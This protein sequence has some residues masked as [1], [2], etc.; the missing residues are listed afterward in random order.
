MAEAEG[1]SLR[2]YDIIYRLTEDIEKALKGMLEPEEV[3][4]VIGHAEVRAVFHI[5]KVGNI[6]GCRVLD[7][8][9]YL[10]PG[11]IKK[12]RDTLEVL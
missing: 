1:V 4:T 6:A 8:E 2:L 3:E 10:K 9:K 12:I 5:S 7:G 11:E